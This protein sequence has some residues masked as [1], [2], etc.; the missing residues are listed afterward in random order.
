[1]KKGDEPSILM[2]VR[3]QHK[4][5]LNFGEDPAKLQQYYY[6]HRRNLGVGVHG[7]GANVDPLFFVTKEYIY[8]YVYKGKAIP[9]QALTG[10]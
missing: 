4:H 5:L 1:V 3:K 6:F 2:K 9:L 10:P 8:I 7:G